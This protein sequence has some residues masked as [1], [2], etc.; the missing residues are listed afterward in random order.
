MYYL[1]YNLQMPAQQQKALNKH[2]IIIAYDYDFIIIF[3]VAI[4][5][6]CLFWSLYNISANLVIIFKD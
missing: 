3:V 1:K 4:I 6:I 5:I 2:Q